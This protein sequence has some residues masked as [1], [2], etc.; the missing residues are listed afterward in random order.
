M[1]TVK[2]KRQINTC[3]LPESIKSCGKVTMIPVV[4]DALG[5]VQKCFEKRLKK[6]EIR[7]RIENTQI[8]ALLS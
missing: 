8:T 2:G 3:M 7:G 6:L 4:G 5:R 1:T